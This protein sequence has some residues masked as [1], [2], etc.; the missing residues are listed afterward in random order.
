MIEI[1][2]K[3]KHFNYYQFILIMIYFILL[4]NITKLNWL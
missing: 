2:I 1:L 3:Y 4:E